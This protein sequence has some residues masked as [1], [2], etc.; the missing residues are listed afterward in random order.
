MSSSGK[1][2][3][4]MDFTKS[5]RLSL[6]SLTRDKSGNSLQPSISLSKDEVKQIGQ[7][8][9][10]KRIGKITLSRLWNRIGRNQFCL[11]KLLLG[12]QQHHPLTICRSR[13]PALLGRSKEACGRLGV[14]CCLPREDACTQSAEGRRCSVQPRLAHVRVWPARFWNTSRYAHYRPEFNCPAD[15]RPRASARA[16]EH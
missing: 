11:R 14:H 16:D 12:Q 4:T 3:F 2:V 1:P 9:D 10:D 5:Q 15:I 7:T 13:P 6:V 8:K